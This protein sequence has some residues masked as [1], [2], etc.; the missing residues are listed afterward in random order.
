MCSKHNVFHS[1]FIGL[2]AVLIVSAPALAQPPKGECPEKGKKGGPH[3]M[4]EELKLNEEQKTKLQEL[5][6]EMHPFRKKQKEAMKA[7]KLKMKEELLKDNPD[8]SV[9]KSHSKE[10]AGLTAKMSNQMTMHLLKVKKVLN[11]EQFE[12]V[13]S[14][15]FLHGMHK[16]K[17]FCKGD[18]KNKG[19][20]KNKNGQ[21]GPCCPQK[22]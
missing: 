19:E 11:K 21:K 18:C 16:N 5:R 12:K 10:I 14:K 9:L 2:M 3:K 20:C 1:F 7:I 17:G 15:D 13:L 8:M 6:K 22:K 4:W